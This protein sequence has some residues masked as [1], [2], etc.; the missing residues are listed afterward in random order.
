MSYV[1]IVFLSSMILAFWEMC[2]D[3]LALNG[4]VLNSMLNGVIPL[5]II[6]ITWHM[7]LTI[8]E[9][10]KCCMRSVYVCTGTSYAIF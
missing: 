4:K 5:A 2:V 7:Y 6:K 9:W 3:I 10:M 1:F 8:S